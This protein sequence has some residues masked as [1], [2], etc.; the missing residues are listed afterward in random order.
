[1]CQKREE[2]E[3]QERQGKDKHK[4]GQVI[5][6]GVPYPS[7]NIINILPSQPIAQGLDISDPKA[8]VEQ[9]ALSPFEIPGPRDAVVKEYGEWQMSN[10]EN[11]TLKAA[12]R[13]VCDMMLNNGLDL[14]QV[15]KDQ[16]PK[17][18]I[19]KGIKIGIARRFVED[20]GKW[21]K[22]VKKAIPLYE[23]L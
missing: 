21:A 10:V 11:D 7:W 23:I 6:I 4:G 13:H 16:D 8:A 2:Q 18:F 9:M 5:G 1:M 15:Y 22:Q 12:F 20:I 14:E 3:R 17:F 19:E